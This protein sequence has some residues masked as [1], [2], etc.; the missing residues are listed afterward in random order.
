MRFILLGMCLFGAVWVSIAQNT[1]PPLLNDEPL[2]LT[3]SE[4]Q[5]ASASY[6]VPAG[7]AHAI[8]L[9]VTADE[10]FDPVVMVINSE[11]RLLAY[12]NNSA[13]SN[14][15]SIHNLWLEAGTYT[16]IVDS[17]NGV[18]EGEVT[19]TLSRTNPFDEMV[20]TDDNRIIISVNLPENTRYR[21]MLP[22]EAD[23]TYTFTLRDRGNTLDPYLRLL[24]AENNK[25]ASNDDHGTVDTR[26]N[27]LD[28]RIPDWQASTE[29]M[30]TLEVRDFLGRSGD[31]ELIITQDSE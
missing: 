14:R 22:V 31:F 23:V 13:Q 1:I 3:V 29:G 10:S 6:T 26:L 2:T 8:T 17:F 21:Y 28:A 16:V 15:A 30:I 24:D 5:R 27:T 19:V 7:D 12:N 25:L 9:T 20:S 4:N 18:N 11:N